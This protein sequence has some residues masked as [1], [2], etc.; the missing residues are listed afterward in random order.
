MVGPQSELGVR[1][2]T[3]VLE[4]GGGRSLGLVR[5]DDERA[6]SAVLNSMWVAREARGGR[7]AATRDSTPR[8]RRSFIAREGVGTLRV[9]AR[10]PIRVAER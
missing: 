8:T 3:F 10:M 2:R 9:G 4:A 5:L 7:A 1:Q 6:G